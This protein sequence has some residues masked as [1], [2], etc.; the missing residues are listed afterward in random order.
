MQRKSRKFPFALLP[1]ATIGTAYQFMM[2]PS[3]LPMATMAT[4]KNDLPSLS[5]P[6]RVMIHITTRRSPCFV[7]HYSLDRYEETLRRNRSFSRHIFPSYH[8]PRIFFLCHFRFFGYFGVNYRDLTF[9]SDTHPSARAF[10]LLSAAFVVASSWAN[11]T[12]SSWCASL[13][14]RSDATFRV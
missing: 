1:I 7:V 3:T 9:L 6:G 12:S 8:E 11:V 10:C 13:H 14:S 2:R 5:G 4:T